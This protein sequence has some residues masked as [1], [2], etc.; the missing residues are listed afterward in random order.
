MENQDYTFP[1][2]VTN[3]HHTQ[4]SKQEK[5]GAYQE[6]KSEKSLQIKY[7]LSKLVAN[8][9]IEK[10]EKMS[11]VLGQQLWAF[12]YLFVESLVLG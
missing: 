9:K 11:I 6:E 10:V 7:M 12:S 2:K 4:T 8:Q 1:W 5:Y 3:R